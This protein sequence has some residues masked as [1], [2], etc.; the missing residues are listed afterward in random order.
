MRIRTTIHLALGTV[1]VLHVFTAVMGHVGLEKSQNDLAIYEGVNSDTLRVLSIDKGIA[2]LQRNVSTYMLSGHRSSAERVRELLEQVRNEIGFAKEQT[3]QNSVRGQL[4][5]MGERIS[6]FENN[7]EKVVVDR[8]TRV[9]LV[10]DEMFPTKEL[11]LEIIENSSAASS[12]LL[13]PVQE[14]VYLA[15]NSALRYFETPGRAMVD[16]A[17]LQIQTAELLIESAGAPEGEA[18]TVLELLFEYERTFLRAVQATQGYMHLVH[19]VLAG[20]T[21]ELLYQSAQIRAGSLERRDSI[22]SS[23][24]LGAKQFQAWSDLVAVL[25]VL[26]G[27][28]TAGLMTRSVLHPILSLTGTLHELAE[29]NADAEI[30]HSNRRDE[31]GKMAKAAEVFRLKN[32][33]TEELLQHSQSMASDLERRNSEMTQFVYTVSHDLK[34]PLVTIQG[35][36]GALKNAIGEGDLERSQGMVERIHNASIRMSQTVEDLLELSRIGMVVNEPE[37]FIFGETCEEVIQDLSGLQLKTKAKIQVSGG[38]SVVFADEHRIRQVLQ[39]LIQNAMVYGM[40]DGCPPEIDITLEQIDGQAVISV[41][42]H[43][44]GIE[45]AY[46]EKVFGIFQRLNTGT[47]GTGVGLAIVRKIA[48]AHGGRAWVESRN[49]NGASFYVSIP[50]ASE[51][52]SS[53]ELKSTQDAA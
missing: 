8:E 34:S 35:F 2:E 51:H 38:D 33:E 1:L 12:T 10:H 22:R 7:F 44:N 23:M 43:G 49:G 18:M 50:Q 26:A 5:A 46:Q 4:E 31:I 13:A 36:A 21:A 39:N 27:L 15:E 11:I 9:R 48:L 6:S 16:E 32:H 24:E 42:D 52:A 20:E 47:T 3:E 29:G 14:H 41:A 19:V 45:E 17:I 28:L 25:T 30:K 40:R 53:T 37:E